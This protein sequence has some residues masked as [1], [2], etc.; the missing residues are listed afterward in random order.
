MAISSTYDFNPDM[1]EIIEEAYERA[2]LEL[3][4]GYDLRTARR[5]LN[6]LTLEWQNRGL[7]LWTIEEGNIS[8]TSAGTS[9]GSSFYLKKDTPSYNIPIA[10][11]SVLDLILR[12]DSG[13]TTLQSD[14]HL[15]R[16]SQPTYAVIPNKL[17]VGRPLQFY[18]QRTEVQDVTSST[19]RNS[20]V[21]IWPVPDEDSK[22]SIVYWRVKRISDTN[23]D[24]SSTAE[25][26]DRFIPALVAGLA[27][28]IAVKKPEAIDRVSM[29][30]QIYEEQFKMAADED[31]VKTSARFVPNLSG[32]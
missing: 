32:Y 26:P 16:I 13:S 22:Y 19:D 29:L 24:A 4:S 21:T 8:E 7:N 1:G 3:R 28:Q 9:L 30:K 5:S 2:G 27:Y 15:N 23:D 11:T 31:R 25:V 14:F 20:K 18:L 12:T 6:L 17:S 10:T